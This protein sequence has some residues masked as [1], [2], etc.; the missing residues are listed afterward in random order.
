MA[1]NVRAMACTPEDVFRVL[2]NGWLYPGWVVG[3]SRMRDV[4]TSWPSP[5]AQLSHSVGVWP[6]LLND[7]T[8]IEEWDPPRRAVL[9]ARGWP[10]GEATVTIRAKTMGSGCQVRI[11]EEPVKGPATLLPSLITTPMLRW[12]NAE[13][14]HRLAY[15]AEGHAS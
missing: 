9:R 12:R 7:T 3:A 11:D 1:T 5:G 13:T 14:L 15:L 2:G 6:A 10:V 4:D 8:Q